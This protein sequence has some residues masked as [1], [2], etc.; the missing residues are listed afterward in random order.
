ME[1]WRDIKGYEGKYQV[2]NLGRVK[3]LKDSHGNYREK[4][5]SNTPTK[6]GYLTVGLYKKGKSKPY[7]VHRLVAEAFIENTNN[8]P[9][10]NHKDEN[11]QNNRV[12]NLEWCT[13]QY[14]NTYGTRT[15]RQSEKMKGVNH[16]MY[17]KHHT[18]NTKNKISISNKGKSPSNRRK[19]QCITTGKIFKSIK[20][21]AEYYSIIRQDISKCCKGKLEST[22]KHPDTGEKLVWKYI[23]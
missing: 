16:P 8:H 22:G 9:I 21:A 15:K 4:I 6:D 5:L 11:K 13:Y 14:N 1:E 23:D 18:E 2:S 3:S 17:G 19:V 12:D 20:E 10:I 7:K